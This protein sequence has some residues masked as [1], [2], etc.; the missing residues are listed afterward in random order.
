MPTVKYGGGSVIGWDLIKKKQNIKKLFSSF[1]K[2]WN[3]GHE[4]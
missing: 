1:K 2:H 4:L 3:T